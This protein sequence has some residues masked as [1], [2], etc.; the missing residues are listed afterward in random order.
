MS[1]GPCLE[2]THRIALLRARE[3][4]QAERALQA[5]DVVAQGA[6]SDRLPM[7]FDVENFDLLADPVERQRR[8]ESEIRG[9]GHVDGKLRLCGDLDEVG[10]RAQRHETGHPFR[11]R[12]G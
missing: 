7:A 10:A 1:R 6:A 12:L 8:A 11:Q 9:R 4:L 2:R 3:Y 5:I